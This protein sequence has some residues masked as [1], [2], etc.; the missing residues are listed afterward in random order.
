M[1]N[2]FLFCLITFE[3]E[4]TQFS[5]MDVKPEIRVHMSEVAVFILGK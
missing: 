4:Q 1:T 5:F 3:N 2:N